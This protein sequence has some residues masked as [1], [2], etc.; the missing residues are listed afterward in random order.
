MQGGTQQ[1]R[2]VV[3]RLCE[4]LFD[5]LR[6]VDDPCEVSVSYFEMFASPHPAA[7]ADERI[8]DLLMPVSQPPDRKQEAFHA[9]LRV[10]E[11]PQF[12]AF[13]PGITDSVA[14]NYEDVA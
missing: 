4:G 11:H 5:G 9:Q 12:G 8:R 2:G 6:D 3:P 7:S 10:C 13:V 14:E 1:H